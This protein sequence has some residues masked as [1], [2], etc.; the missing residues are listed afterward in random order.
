M[1]SQSSQLTLI[2]NQRMSPFHFIF[3]AAITVFLYFEL[4][5]QVWFVQLI[6]GYL[7]KVWLPPFLLFIYLIIK[8]MLQGKFTLHID[9]INSMLFFYSVFGLISMVINEET[10]HL[11]IKYYLIMIA[12]IWFYAVII[13]NFK[14]NRDIEKMLRVLVLAIFALSIYTQYIQIKYSGAPHGTVEETTTSAGSML[15]LWQPTIF[16]SEK[17]EFARGT[18]AY[19]QGK[20]CGMLAPAILFSLLFF[21]KANR[22]TKYFYIAM[23]GFVLFQIINTVSRAGIASTLVGVSMLIAMLF[24]HEKN[25]RKKVALLTFLILLI[26]FIFLLRYEMNVLFIRFAQILSAIGFEKADIYLDAFGFESFIWGP[27]SIDP[28]L[29]SIGGSLQSFMENPLLGKGYIF[30]EITINEHNRYLFILI[31]SG[32]LTLIPYVLFIAG[33]T[34]WVRKKLLNSRYRQEDGVNYLYFFYSCNVMFLVK[35]L[36][37]GMETFFY[38]ILFALASAWVRNLERDYL[39]DKSHAESSNIHQTSPQPASP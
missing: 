11:A 37:E 28:H 24:L 31:S 6:G 25:E 20:Y 39:R 9:F 5:T 22:S 35:L 19:E 16:S 18:T 30:S 26:L 8:M 34:F 38:W 14:D 27:S 13:D 15:A 12:P 23:S 33:L 7:V 4:M 32:L 2:S 17:I 3:I 1:Y 36:N 29:Y 10:L 21:I